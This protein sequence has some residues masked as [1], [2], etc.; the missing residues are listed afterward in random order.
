MLGRTRDGHAQEQLLTPRPRCSPCVAHVRDE[1]K[2][3]EHNP[4][5]HSRTHM[6]PTGTPTHLR[7]QEQLLL[8]PHDCLE[9][10]LLAHVV[11]AWGP[12]GVSRGKEQQQ[13]YSLQHTATVP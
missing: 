9:H 2:R 10:V 13:E 4:T 8:L 7:G 12:G 1:F 6:G 3:D 11:G 5:E